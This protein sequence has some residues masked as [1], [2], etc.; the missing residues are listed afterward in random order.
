MLV[1]ILS[2]FFVFIAAV[3]YCTDL[4]LRFQ[5]IFDSMLTYVFHF[6]MIDLEKEKI[7]HSD[8]FVCF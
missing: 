3:L 2:R 1:K 7:F 4:Q 8:Y 6:I 5:V